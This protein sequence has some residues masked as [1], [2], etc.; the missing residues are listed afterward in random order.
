MEAEVEQLRPREN[1]TAV[2]H[3]CIKTTDVTQNHK[4]Q[5]TPR[6]CVRNLIPV[7]ADSIFSSLLMKERQMT[8]GMSTH[9]YPGRSLPLVVSACAGVSFEGSTPYIPPSNKQHASGWISNDIS[10]FSE[11]GVS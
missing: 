2:A 6:K 9:G 7:T 11:K 4:S 8:P 3:A 5:K 10:M 1:N